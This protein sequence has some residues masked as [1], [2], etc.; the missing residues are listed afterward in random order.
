MIRAIL[1]PQARGVL[2]HALS[3]FGP[4]LAAHGVTTDAYWQILV[5]VAM[6]LLAV[7]DS[8]KTKSTQEPKQ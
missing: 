1:S 4:L 3:S 8:I 2:R 6:A 5:G 7:W